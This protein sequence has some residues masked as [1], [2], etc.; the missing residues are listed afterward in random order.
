MKKALFAVALAIAA[1]GANAAFAVEPS[2]ASTSELPAA[3]KAL[4]PSQAQILSVS[5]A[6]QIRGEGWGGFHGRFGSIN[7]NTNITTNITTT[8]FINS[9]NTYTNS[10]NSIR[11]R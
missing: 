4:N 2:K 8:T 9:F 3:L 6:Q 5:E 11:F 1:L 7:I 10:F